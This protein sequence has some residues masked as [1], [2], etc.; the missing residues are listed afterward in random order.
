VKYNLIAKKIKPNDP[1]VL[2]NEKFF[3][4]LKQ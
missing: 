2:T 3:A 1:S 4:T